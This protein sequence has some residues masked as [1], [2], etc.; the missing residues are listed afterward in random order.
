MSTSPEAAYQAANPEPASWPF[1]EIDDASEQLFRELQRRVV[2]IMK[3]A[4]EDPDN[5]DLFTIRCRQVAYGIES[6][7]KG[8][9]L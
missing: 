9:R 7:T 3:A 2:Q 4:G 8:M 5:A 6:R 1:A